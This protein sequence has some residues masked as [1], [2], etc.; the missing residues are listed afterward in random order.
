VIAFAVVVPVLLFA[1]VVLR[2]LQGPRIVSSRSEVLNVPPVGQAAPANLADGRPVFVVHQADGTVGVIDGISTHVPFGLAKLNVWCR[3]SQ[4][5]EDLFHGSKWTQDGDY[6]LGPAPTGLVTYETTMLPDG[7]VEVGTAIAA[8]PR[9]SDSSFQPRG[10][11]CETSTNIL[12]PTLPTQVFESP[13]EVVA[14]SPS[15]WVAMKGQLTEV[16]GR[17]ELCSVYTAGP[18]CPDGVVVNGLD[19]T[20]LFGTN[21]GTVIP[22]TFI[23]RVVDDSLVDL[24]RVPLA[25]EAY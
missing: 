18:G 10:P 9:S 6:V 21:S 2:S 14:A 11:F 3:S 13:S 4:L 23:A 5:F 7:Q 20:G 22:G 1:W 16:A 17:A 24:T 12:Y 25:G 8:V 15:G 19:L